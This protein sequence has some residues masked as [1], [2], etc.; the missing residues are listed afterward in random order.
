MIVRMNNRSS[1]SPARY[2]VPTIIFHW[3]CAAIIVLQ[4]ATANLWGLFQNPLHHQLV[5]TH[6]TAGMVL[7]V[8]FPARLL[9]RLGWGRHIRAADRWLDA[10]LARSV[11]YSL[12]GLVFLEIFLGYMWRWGNGQAMSFLSIQFMPPFGKFSASTISLLHWLHQWNGW[13]IIVLATGHAL[14][15]CFHYFILRDD[16]FQRMLGTGDISD[17]YGK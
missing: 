15:A 8:L 7:S 13:L 16:V 2:D 11:E 14:A 1:L 17:E 6:L 10:V 5:V 12:Y 9:W 3:G 4:F